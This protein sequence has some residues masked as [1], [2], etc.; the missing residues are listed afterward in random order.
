MSE[1]QDLREM[2]PTLPESHQAQA[3][4]LLNRMEEV[5]EGIDDKVVSWSPPT[6]K[7]IQATSEREKGINP[8]DVILN[9]E[10]IDL[11][12]FGRVIVLAAWVERRKWSDDLD[13]K[14]ADCASPD[15]KLGFKYGDCSKCV[16]SKWNEEEN[17]S[18]GCDQSHKFLVITEDLEHLFYVIFHRTA[19]TN[20]TAWKNDLKRGGKPLHQVKYSLQVVD[21]AKHRNVSQ[22][23]IGKREMVDAGMW[24]FLEALGR[25]V[26]SDRTAYLEAYRTSVRERGQQDQPALA[27]QQAGADRMIEAPVENTAAAGTGEEEQYSL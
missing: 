2:I 21:S 23:S 1:Y 6:L 3:E 9:G 19:Y 18:G 12:G 7:L 17:K 20:G 11:E 25:R 15:A 8:G 14:S 16:Y 24:K 5:V 4:A 22:V 26:R 27:N 13:D 10:K